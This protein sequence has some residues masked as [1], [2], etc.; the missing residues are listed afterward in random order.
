MHH[1]AISSPPS[2]SSECEWSDSGSDLRLR[3]FPSLLHGKR[4]APELPLLPPATHR[5]DQPSPTKRDEALPVKRK[6]LAKPR[7]SPRSQRRFSFDLAAGFGGFSE[8]EGWNRRRSE[9]IFLHDATTTASQMSLSAPSSTIQS[10]SSSSGSAPSL[11]PKT[12]SKPKTTPPSREGKDVVKVCQIIHSASSAFSPVSL[13]S[14]FFVMA[15]PLASKCVYGL[16]ICVYLSV[17]ECV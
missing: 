17:Y 3:K 7:P 4:A 16:N 1:W 5:A 10:S 2:G 8:D 11:T 6:S 14:S 12:P 13:S 9:R 15:P